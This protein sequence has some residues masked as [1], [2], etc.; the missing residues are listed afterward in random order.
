MNCPAP[1]VPRRMR[2]PSSS[3]NISTAPLT[4]RKTWSGGSPSLK[5]TSPLVKCLRVIRSFNQERVAEL[6]EGKLSWKQICGHAAHLLGHNTRITASVVQKMTTV[7]TAH[8]G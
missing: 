3:R 8:E 6:N 2:S 7:P 4:R 1:T 5:R